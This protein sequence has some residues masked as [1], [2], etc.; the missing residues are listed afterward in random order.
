MEKPK[1]TVPSVHLNGTS[2]AGLHDPLVRAGSDISSA[3]GSLAECAPHGRDYYIQ[4]ENAYAK[5]RDE[6]LSRIAR[7]QSVL[8]EI[9]VLAR[10][11]QK[12]QDARTAR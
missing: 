12:A 9:K 5:A 4:G 6:H 10:Q 8:D 1:L 3:I 2:F 7:L 11:V